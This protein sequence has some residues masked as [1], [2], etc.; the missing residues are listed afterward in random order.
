LALAAAGVAVFFTYPIPILNLG[1]VGFR[2]EMNNSQV[3]LRA[4][5][6]F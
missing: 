4:G 3:S 6:R 1:L 5:Y 2:Q